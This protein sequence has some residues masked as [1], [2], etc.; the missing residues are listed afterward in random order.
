MRLTFTKET[1][2]KYRGVGFYILLTT[3]VCLAFSIRFV[4]S[5]SI[6][7][8][9][10]FIL[11]HPHAKTM[12]K[13]AFTNFYFLSFLALFLMQLIGLLYTSDTSEGWNE[14]TKKAG[15]LAIPFFFCAYYSLP[16]IAMRRLLLYFSISLVLVSLYCFVFAFVQFN[17]TGDYSVFFYHKL[18]LPV[19]HH[20]VF[21]SFY[22]FYCLLYWMEELWHA[23]IRSKWLIAL[24]LFFLIMII[25]LSSKIV[26]IIT[27]IYL[28]TYLFRLFFARKVRWILPLILLFLGAATAIMATTDN[29]VRKRF[30]ELFEG[31]NNLFK[32]EKFSPDIYFNGLQFRLLTW[33]FTG[34]IL[35]K[36]NAWLAGVSPGDAQH[37]LN[38]KY[39]GTNMYLGGNEPGDTGFWNFNCHNLY[40]QT[41]LESGLLGLSFLLLAIGLFINEAVRLRN[42]AALV[43]FISMLIFGF[44]ES[45]LSS[46]YPI[47][48]F[49]FF[50]LLSLRSKR[51]KET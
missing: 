19:Q 8:L 46:Q 15:Y 22:I 51:V 41:V 14:V 36:E 43:F 40:L 2:S 37:E 50:P 30:T 5:L 29:P 45:V 49:L 13:R 48:L 35:E 28:S 3:L 26:I 33:R 11:V 47:L 31:N 7:A 34:E 17:K 42:H 23:S 25:L 10:V 24:L 18:V 16:S 9:V 38:K 32:Q 39:T 27:F 44:T 1:D 4:N 21:F 6:V 12:F 20:A